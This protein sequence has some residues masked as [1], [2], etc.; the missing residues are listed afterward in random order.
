MRR[1]ISASWFSG[2]LTLKGR[3]A[4]LSTVVR[5]CVAELATDV[6]ASIDGEVDAAIVWAWLE[7]ARRK[8]ATVLFAID[9]VAMT[10]LHVVS[11]QPSLAIQW[12]DRGGNLSS[13]REPPYW[14]MVS[15]DARVSIV[16]ASRLRR[17]VLPSST[18]RSARARRSGAIRSLHAFFGGESLPYRSST[19][20]EF[21]LPVK[22]VDSVNTVL[23]VDPVRTYG[24][25]RSMP[26]SDT[27]PVDGVYAHVPYASR[28]TVQ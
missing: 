27:A 18:T 7:D 21:G 25:N 11:G 6:L 4:V 9:R 17:R 2:T 13:S 10:H 22:L 20:V 28:R 5:D 1:R 15:I 14:T 3:M 19:N 23:V 16:G 12:A 26:S 24:P 8:R